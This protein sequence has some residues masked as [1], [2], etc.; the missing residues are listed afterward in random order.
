MTSF[1]F[2]DLHKEI[3][4]W[5]GLL[6][7]VTVLYKMGHSGSLEESAS[8]TSAELNLPVLNRPLIRNCS[9]NFLVP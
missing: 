9:F 2:S 3:N 8:R 5:V 1:R 7:N 6:I 4:A